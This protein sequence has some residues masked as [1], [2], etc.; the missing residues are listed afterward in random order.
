MGNKEDWEELE[1]WAEN[2]RL[3][4]KQ[5]FKMDIDSIDMHQRTKK[6]SIVINF[7]KAIFKTTKII[8][9]LGAVIMGGAVFTFANV[10]FSN[11]NSSVNADVDSI[12]QQYSI[13]MKIVSQETDENGNGTYLITLKNKKEI[14]FKAIKKYGDLKNDYEAN[15]NKYVFEHWDSDI[16]EKFDIME[17]LDENGMLNYEIYINVD[18]DGDIEQ[19]TEYL[20][21]FL[22]YAEKWN[23]ENKIVKISQQKNNQFVVPIWRIY[24]KIQEK[25]IYPYNMMF[26]TADEIREEDKKQYY[27]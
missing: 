9:V 16:K 5:T 25:R 13:K 14:Q 21:N 3:K 26:Q 11:F 15:Y 12:A 20:I 19:A 27:N 10:G 7:L 4:R 18:K 24:I 1:K 22:E 2:E 23:K 8:F 17:G 6:M